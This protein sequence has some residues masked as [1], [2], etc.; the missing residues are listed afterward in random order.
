MKLEEALPALCAG[1]VEGIRC[2]NWIHGNYWA[3]RRG[4]L[5]RVYPDELRVPTLVAINPYD[6]L[7]DKWSVIKPKP[8]E[9]KPVEHTIH[10]DGPAYARIRDGQQ[11]AVVLFGSSL[12]FHI[13]ETLLIKEDHDT[14]EVLVAKVTH[15]EVA[16]SDPL[17]F[18]VV[19]FRLTMGDNR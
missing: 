16:I 9:P 1:E 11:S 10:V 19:H 12:A 6:L 15:V 8:V 5:V 17:G 13:G 14:G 3:I 2:D 7:S 18:Q 4:S